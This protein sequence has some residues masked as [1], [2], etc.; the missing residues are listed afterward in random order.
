MWV[1]VHV[2]SVPIV[3]INVLTLIQEGGMLEML[4][5]E[6]LSPRSLTRHP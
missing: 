5:Q 4:N 1:W 2:C 6:T 3:I